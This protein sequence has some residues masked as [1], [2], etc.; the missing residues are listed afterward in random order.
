MNYKPI[1]IRAKCNYSKAPANQE[2]TI[3]PQGKTPVNMAKVSPLKKPLVGDQDKL[4][5]HLKEKILASPA[6][7]YK[8]DAQRKAV[9][10]SK[11]DGGKGAP[12]KMYKS[13]AKKKGCKSPAKKY[14]SPAKKH[15]Y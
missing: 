3:D 2:V 6:K 11:A 15:C 7:G 9:H 1:T 4:P 14:K 5:Q 12:N 8:S 13:P 10:A